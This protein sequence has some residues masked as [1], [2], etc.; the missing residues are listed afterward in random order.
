MAAAAK[1]KKQIEDL[2]VSDSSVVKA[3]ANAVS[4]LIVETIRTDTEIINTIA[5]NISS[6][7]DF[8]KAVMNKFMEKAKPMKQEIYESL[9]FDNNNLS[10]KVKGKESYNQLKLSNETLHLEILSNIDGEIVSFFTV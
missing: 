10:I 1:L 7:D 9:S 5:S 8:S 4:S 2:I 3:I 6:N